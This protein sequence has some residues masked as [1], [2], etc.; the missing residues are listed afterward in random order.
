MNCK[1][2]KMR[3]IGSVLFGALVFCACSDS[4]EFKIDTS[5]IAPAE[6]FTDVRDGQTY[7]CIRIGNQTWMAENLNYYLPHGG[8]DGSFTW[9]EPVYDTTSV[10]ISEDEFRAKVLEAIETGEIKPVYYVLPFGKIEMLLDPLNSMI[11]QK[12]PSHR[13]IYEL[14]VKAESYSSWPQYAEVVAGINDAIVVLQRISK[15]LIL[16]NIPGFARQHFEE[17]EKGNSHYSSTYGMLYTYEGALAAVPEGWRL[18]DDE[19]WKQLEK[20][21]GMNAG[22]LD[23][24]DQ[25]RGEGIGKALK[26]GEEGIGFNALYGGCNA[27][28]PAK[29]EQYIRMGENAYFWSSSKIV[30]NDSTQLGIIRSLALFEE[31]IMR[32]TTMLKGYLPVMYHVRCIKKEENE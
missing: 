32:S 23:A 26:A 10:S 2:N 16:E 28:T 14:N 9:N 5:G 12:Y 25:W 22:E 20:Y 17:Y 30:V 1:I 15:R 3:T 21:L 19:D 6:A 8:M 4:P 29:D 31:G 27:Y 13:I 24:F 18:P 11:S 7:Q